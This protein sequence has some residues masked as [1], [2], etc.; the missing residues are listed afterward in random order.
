MGKLTARPIPD[1]REELQHILQVCQKRPPRLPRGLP[2][3]INLRGRVREGPYQPRPQEGEDL[4]NLRCFQVGPLQISRIFP[5]QRRDPRQGRS[6]QD[7]ATPLKHRSRQDPH[8]ELPLHQ[9][10]LQKRGRQLQAQ[11]PEVLRKL[12][13]VVDKDQGQHPADR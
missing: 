12:Q 5:P 4:P 2:D 3:P 10:A 13:G 6:L 9:P 11:R 1:H 7:H 8:K